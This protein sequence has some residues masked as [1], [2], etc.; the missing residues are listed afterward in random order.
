MGDQGDDVGN[1][2][3]GSNERKQKEI[4]DNV[5]KQSQTK[6]ALPRSSLNYFHLKKKQ[7]PSTIYEAGINLSVLC[8]Q[9]NF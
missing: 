4:K 1:E 6:P 9:S 3:K 5:K 8:P 2:K 7:A